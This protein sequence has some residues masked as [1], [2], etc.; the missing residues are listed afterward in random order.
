V[1]YSGSGGLVTF[2]HAAGFAGDIFCPDAR[3]LT[4][5]QRSALILAERANVW[6]VVATSYGT[7]DG[8]IP[9]VV[10]PS[11]N[12][13]S[14]YIN[15]QGSWGVVPHT[16]TGALT[17]DV[18]KASGSTTTAIAAGVIV[19]A[20]VNASAAIA[21]TKTGALTGEVT[22][23]SGSAATVIDRTTAFTWTG[24]HT[25]S[26]TVNL[27][28]R[29]VLA[30][31][32]TATVSSDQDDW[33]PTGISGANV[34]RINCTSTSEITG[35]DASQSGGRVLVL[36]NVGSAPVNFGGNGDTSSAAANRFIWANSNGIGLS[37]GGAVVIWYDATSSRWRAIACC[38]HYN[39]E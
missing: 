35:I 16:A 28:N 3:D 4:M 7:F 12:S 27:A 33:S 18:T 29:L 32:I 2:E 15:G 34:V 1:F 20:D 26:S 39:R 17:G 9:G 14:E 8:T 10:P 37:V 11:N 30:S 19:N 25:F 6:R 31:I 21:Q 23:A 36:I 13:A 22:K 5:G 24:I 38:G